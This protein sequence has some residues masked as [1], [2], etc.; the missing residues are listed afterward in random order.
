[1]RCGRCVRKVWACCIVVCAV[2]FVLGPAIGFLLTGMLLSAWINLG[3][4][5]Y[6]LKVGDAAWAGAWWL[7]FI[8]AAAIA[9]AISWIGLLFPKH[10]DNTEHIRAALETSPEVFRSGQVDADAV[11]VIG[12]QDSGKYGSYSPRESPVDTISPESSDV[13]Q[14]PQ[15]D[16][17]PSPTLLQSLRVVFTHKVTM[18]VT[19]A[20]VCDALIVNAFSSFLP[21][22]FQAQW[23]LTPGFASILTGIIVVPGAAGGALFGGW[24]IKRFKMSVSTM[25]K[26]A[27]G[28][29]TVSTLLLFCLLLRCPTQKVSGINFP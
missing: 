18:L 12:Q 23:S 3:T 2:G 1:M 15:P 6:G 24:M 22:F 27:A 29:S 11:S 13:L 5:P 10:M 20:S 21:K 19:A 8:F 7:P 28:F 4:A 17:K 25:T 26:A 9:F 14:L 16:R